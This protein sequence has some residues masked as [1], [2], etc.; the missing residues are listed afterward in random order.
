MKGINEMMANIL[1]LHIIKT[2]RMFISMMKTSKDLYTWGGFPLSQVRNTII[3]INGQIRRLYIPF[4]KRGGRLLS[5][6]ARINIKIVTS[7]ESAFLKMV[8]EYLFVMIKA[9]R[10]LI[11][12]N[13]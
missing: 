10:K 13:I 8:K 9:G 3:P 4:V 11:V 1:R 12:L 2:I 7:K 5:K 6:L